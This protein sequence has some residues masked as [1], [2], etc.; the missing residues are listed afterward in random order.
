VRLERGELHERG[1]RGIEVSGYVEWS[2]QSLFQCCGTCVLAA[3]NVADNK[4][5][6]PGLP[7]MGSGL[8][9]ILGRL[10]QQHPAPIP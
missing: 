2:F 8:A 6:I 7:E 3:A 10:R 5:P 1:D 4:K 9:E